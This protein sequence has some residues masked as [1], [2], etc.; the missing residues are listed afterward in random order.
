METPSFKD[1]LG[2]RFPPHREMETPSSQDLGSFSSFC[3]METMSSINLGN[4]GHVAT[5]KPK[6]HGM[7]LWFSPR[8]EMETPKAPIIMQFP[9]CHEI[10][11][12]G[13]H[14]LG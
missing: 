8:Q 2:K 4:F 9:S 13:F 7:G 14:E 6:F 5:W 12:P 10:E 3:N 1:I 11:A